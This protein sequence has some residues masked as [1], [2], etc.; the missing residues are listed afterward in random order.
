MLA[1]VMGLAAYVLWFLRH[2]ILLI[3]VS[4]L[5]AVIF[6]PVVRRIQRVSL[7]KSHPSQG[8]AIVILLAAIAAVLA[9]LFLIVLPPIL[10]DAQGLA[11]DLPGQ[12][13]QLS[14]KLQD[15]PF[16][17]KL[18]TEL[19]PDAVVQHFT[20][21]LRGGLNTVLGL[22]GGIVDVLLLALLIPYFI[23]DGRF[24]F[25]WSLSLV[26]IVD[27]RRLSTTLSRGAHRAQRWL[28]GQALLMLILASLTAVVLG[29]LHVRYFYALAVL[30]GLANF[31]P[32]VGLIV[33][34]ALASLAALFD[35]WLK[36]LGVI[37]FYLSYQQ[38]ENAYLSPRIMQSNVGL[39]PVVVIVALAVGGALAGILGA[40]VAVPTA[41]IIA[42]MASEYFI[43][44]ERV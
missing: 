11:Q 4:V 22:A 28:T 38:L 10:H 8:M 21:L 18:A 9:I 17:P 19:K 44:N 33:T 3:Y 29:A 24:A 12:L 37:I 25:E 6:T 35:S 26:P 15:F 41:A 2:T 32:V 36:V 1:F 31:V 43:R 14:H 30:A 23:L 40:L 42:T 13:Q 39:A 27:R 20:D 34:V 7:G 16:G 5:L